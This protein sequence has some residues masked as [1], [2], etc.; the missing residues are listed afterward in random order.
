MLELDVTMSVRLLGRE[1]VGI[2]KNLTEVL[3][4]DERGASLTLSVVVYD[5]DGVLI[6]IHWH[7]VSRSSGNRIHPP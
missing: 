4:I 7:H 2:E 5:A 6:L 1:D 3:I